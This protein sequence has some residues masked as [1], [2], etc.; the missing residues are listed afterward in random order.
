MAYIILIVYT[1]VDYSF[2]TLY[3]SLI[4]YSIYKKDTKFLIFSIFLFMVNANYFNYTIGGKPKGHFLDVLIIYFSIFSPFVFIYFIYSLIKTIKQPT[5]LW[6]V[7]SVALLFSILLSFRQRIKIDDFA[8]FVIISVVFMLAVFLKDYRI[9][10]KPFRLLYKK[11]FIFLFISL[12]IF[13]CLLFISPYIFNYKIFAQFTTSNKIYKFCKTHNINYVKCNNKTL[14]QKLYFYGLN[15][16]NYYFIDFD[17][18]SKKVSI[19]HNHKVLYNF[20]VSKLNK[21]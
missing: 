21:K 1:I 15:K 6:F 10:L 2:F 9:R 8:P 12:I 5:L 20:Y 13:D 19:S 16:G 14:C 11:L 3:L 7:S 4:F 18:N 17:K